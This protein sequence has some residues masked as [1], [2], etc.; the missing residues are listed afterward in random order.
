MSLPTKDKYEE[1]KEK[2]KQEQ[3]RR[4]QKERQVRFSRYTSDFFLLDKK[5]PY[6]FCFNIFP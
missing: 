3:E 2:R 5:L 6:V 4:L 1:L